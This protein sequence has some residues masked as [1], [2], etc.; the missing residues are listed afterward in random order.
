VSL[1]QVRPPAEAVGW[2][3]SCG[4]LQLGA[5]ARWMPLDWDDDA[6]AWVCARCDDEP[7]GLG[8]WPACPHPWPELVSAARRQDVDWQPL[9]QCEQC[10]S[11]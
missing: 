1:D 2:C 10:Q 3:H 9:L 5:A 11:D 7:W 4:V 8:V 6:P